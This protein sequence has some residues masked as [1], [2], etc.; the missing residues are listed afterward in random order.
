MTRIGCVNDYKPD[1]DWNIFQKGHEVIVIIHIKY[2]NS[3]F[4]F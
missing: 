1:A 2:S 3:Y 4:I